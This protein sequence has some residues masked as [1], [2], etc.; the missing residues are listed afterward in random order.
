MSQY[1]VEFAYTPQAWAA[2]VKKPQNRL[3]VVRAAAKKLGGEVSNAWFTF[4][5]SDVVCLV[6]MPDNTSAA[7]FVVAVVA[8]GAMRSSRTTPLMSLEE[9]MEAMKKAG[10]TGYKPPKG[11]S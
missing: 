3:E 5:Q 2:L 8:G 6:E 4:G 1:L 11:A 9:G 7:A 10:S